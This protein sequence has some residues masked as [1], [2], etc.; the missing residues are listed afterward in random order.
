MP[1]KNR[2]KNTNIE[3][4]LE[5]VELINKIKKFKTQTTCFF[6]N[7]GGVGKTTLV[8]NLGAELSINFGAKVLIVDA[9][10]QCNLTQ[11]VLT[12]TETQQ[13]YGQDNPDSIYT[14]IR[15]LSLGKGYESDLPIRNVESFGFDI[16]VGD[17]RLA[18][19]ED[20]LAGDW[21]DAKG[22]G[23]RGIRT[24][25]VFA[26]LVKK[27]RELNYDFVF[28]DM[29]PSLGA[30]N[31]AVL[32]AM[33]FF[34]VPMSIDVFSLWAIKNIGS[35]VSIWKKELDTGIKLSEEPNELSQLSPQGKLR[36]LG[37][38]TQQ[39][40]ERSGYDTVHLDNTEEIKTKR[41][42]QAYEDIGES[43]PS[44]ITEYLSKLYAAKSMDPHLGDIRHLGS[45]AP[46]SQSQH[47]PMIS[48][49]GT[50]NYTR[51]R[52]SARELYRDI[53]RRYLENIQEANSEK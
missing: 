9:D 16:I 12:D 45:L 8:A 29:G 30:I 44:K 17:P 11:Y 28:F 1:R 32:L 52:K 24:T 26:E 6:N 19:Q 4:T 20:L 39:H 15:P 34:V 10:P 25:Y 21:R 14:V 42:V 40:K 47:V 13:L 2:S 33:E 23:M 38:V 53:A 48:V 36:F 5:D 41:R 46:K 51:L 18:L 43:F 3:L 31:R 49:S 50:G 7:K 35:T 37:Y 22:G 27:A